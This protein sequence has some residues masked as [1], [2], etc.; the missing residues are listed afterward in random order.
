MRIQKLLF[1]LLFV[2]LFQNQILAQ[3]QKSKIIDSLVQLDFQK[4]YDKFSR[5][6]EKDYLAAELYAN[7]YLKKAKI[8]QEKIKIGRGYNFLASIYS[9]DLN[10]NITYLDS[11]ISI[12]KDINHKNTLFPYT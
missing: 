10:K 3:N 8:N 4:I 2:L 5:T 1:Y 6:R 9:Y 12:T 11:A 7:A